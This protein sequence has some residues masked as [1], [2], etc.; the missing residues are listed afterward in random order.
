MLWDRCVGVWEGRACCGGVGRG[1]HR[2]GE[3]VR[4]ISPTSPSAALPHPLPTHSPP[5]LPTLVP[6]PPPPLPSRE[7]KRARHIGSFESEE[8]AARAYDREAIKM[9]GP[10]A[11]LNFRESE[12]R[13]CVCVGGDVRL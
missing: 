5:T 10:D 1:G 12:W 4:C 7:L 11:G 2:C 8:D 3:G 6:P 13:V 9:L